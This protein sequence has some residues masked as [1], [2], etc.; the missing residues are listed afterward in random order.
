M[1]TL[2]E[3][4]QMP[5]LTVRKEMFMIDTSRELAGKI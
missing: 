2:R 1:S 3:A 5:S 4:P